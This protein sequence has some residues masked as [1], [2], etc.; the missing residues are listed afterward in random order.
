MPKSTENTVFVRLVPTPLHKVMRHQIEDIFSQIGPI[1][2]SSWINSQNNDSS[3][4]YGFVKYVVKE[5]AEASAKD[6]HDTKIQM[7]GQE[8]KLKVEL[9][10]NQPEQSTQKPKGPSSP[11]KKQVEASSPKKIDIPEDDPAFMKKKSR[12]IVRNLSF[13]AKESHIRKVLESRYGEVVEVH[14]PKVKSNLHVGFCFVTF[15]NPADAKKAVDDKSV[16]IQKRTVSMDWSIP[17][18]LHQ[19]QQKEQKQEE[20]E[21]DDADEQQNDKENDNED[22]DVST[23]SKNNGDTE[24]E[25]DG[26]DDDDGHDDEE[27]DMEV[28]NVD[29]HKA[30][31]KSRSAAIQEKRTLFLRNLPFD[32]TRHDVFELFSKFG[33]I[34]SIYLVKDKSTGML[35]GTAFVTYAKPQST[36]R[37]LENAS[38]A[39]ESSFVSQREAMDATSKQSSSILLR[40]RPVFV[41]LAVD[42]E[43]AETF[44]SKEVKNISADRRNMYLQ[45]EARVE[46]SSTDPNANNANTWDDLPEQDQKKR[47]TALKDKTT[48]L[49]SPIFF[50]NPNRLSFRNMAKHVDEVG[51][52]T[53]IEKATKSALEKNLVTAKDQI[54]HWR[55]LGEMSTRDILAKVQSIEEEGGD[56]IPAWEGKGNIKDYVPSV[57]ID[58]DFGP[59]GKKANAPS[60]G[61]GFAEFTHHV[62]ALACLRELNNNPAYSSDYAAGGKVATALKKKV[63]KGR[64][65]VVKGA[66]GGDFISED[67]R[68][69]VPR[70]IVDFAV[71]NKVKAKKQSER[72]LQQ[73]LN[74][75]KQ[76]Q[77][78]KEKS[79]IDK[80]KRS[81]GSI[82][83]EKKRVR[84]ESGEEIAEKN[85]KVAKDEYNKQKKQQREERKAKM[86]A[87]KKAMVKPAKKKKK[88]DAEDEHFESLVGKY[89][90]GLESSA[91]TQNPRASV[92]KKR[93]FE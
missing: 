4:G 57:F 28:D 85:A 71:E 75:T 70:L 37:A 24:S 42:R 76:R 26:D 82:Q 18:N 63:R 17:K 81:R 74:N 54:A 38:S 43:T 19:Q 34:E 67:G 27:S 39:A 14:V 6:L 56:L 49:Q 68:V 77:E 66:A 50:I 29:D 79:E 61:F 31:Q 12:I 20:A 93:W 64:A 30:D 45:A 1:K 36:Q 13:Y 84:R 48:K 40:G 62:H 90:S 22:D 55:A 47:Q 3:K 44:D 5:D 72:R 10:S 9:A 51:L 65:K 73:Q 46:S 53:L 32:A 86:T 41:N 35:K 60:R 87:E 91:P 52:Q 7:E 8:Y 80:K 2:K 69:R 92:E 21:E 15:R 25:E 83:R 88:M 11:T 58:R 59:E 78:K 23:G 33:Y 16:S 89:K